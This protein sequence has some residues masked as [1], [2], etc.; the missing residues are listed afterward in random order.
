MKKE[1]KNSKKTDVLRWILL[2]P[3]VILSWHIVE[4]MASV[5]ARWFYAPETWEKLGVTVII[6]G[7]FVL[8]CLA[9]FFTARYI[10]PKYK[11]L[12]AWSTVLL[13]VLFNVVLIYGL[14]KMAY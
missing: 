14:S 3:A 13:C 12:I 6:M 7:L 4:F 5:V 10:A 2:V 9:V 1:V 11:N 8:P